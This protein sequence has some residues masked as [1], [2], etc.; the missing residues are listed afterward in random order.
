MRRKSRRFK[1]SSK[2]TKRRRR[3]SKRQRGGQKASPK[4]TTRTSNSTHHR[5]TSHRS[6]AAIAQRMGI[7][8]DARFPSRGKTD[9][10]G[11]EIN[12]TYK[13]NPDQSSVDPAANVRV[14]K[15]YES[16]QS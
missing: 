14:R 13:M 16:A 10:D 9:A 3:S 4:P 1:R 11:A 8:W 2:N 7:V 6:H 5:K 15:V 12:L